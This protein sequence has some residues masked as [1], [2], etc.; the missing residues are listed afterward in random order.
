MVEFSREEFIREF[1]KSVARRLKVFTSR[2]NV[3]KAR[4]ALRELLS[5][6][7]VVMRPDLNK[8]RFEG[9]LVFPS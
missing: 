4:E 6:G 5:D 2:V 1:R 7:R 3:A 9:T 8:E